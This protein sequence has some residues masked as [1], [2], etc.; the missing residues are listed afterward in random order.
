MAKNEISNTEHDDNLTFGIVITG[1]GSK[2]KHIEDLASDIFQQ[3]IKLGQP[4]SI[5]GINDII[6]N[7]RYATTIGL[8]KY[9]LENENS[10]IENESINKNFTTTIK[11]NLEKFINYL[12]I[13]NKGDNM[14]FE[15]ANLSDQKAK[16][17]VI[18]VG[19]GGGNAINRM[20]EDGMNSVEL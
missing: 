15:P 8:I 4:H 14:L 18:G 12:N 11:N 16:I 13:K 17:L 7:P 6:T 5:N 19:G 2:L 1:G 3:D 9:A 10:F 20:I